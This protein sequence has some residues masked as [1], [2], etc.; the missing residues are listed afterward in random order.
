MTKVFKPT[1]EQA[2]VIAFDGS[3]FITACPGAGKTRVLIERA[4]HLL[5]GTDWK[6][7]I[8]FLSF[9]EVAVSELDARLRREGL[10]PSPAMPH[11]IGTFDSFLWRVLVAPFG[12]SGS[13]VR[14]RLIPDLELREVVPFPKARAIPLKCF[15]RVTGLGIPKALAELNIDAASQAHMT[16]ATKMRARFKARGELDYEDARLL[17]LERLNLLKKDS[18][19]TKALVARFGEIIVDEAQD[20]NP[21]D[22]RIIQWFRDAGIPVKVICDPHQSIYGF[23]GGVSTELVAFAETFEKGHRLSLTGNFRSSRNIVSAISRLKRP[24]VGHPYDE[25]LGDHRT[26]PS[27]VYLLAYKGTSVPSNIGDYF[28]KLVTELQVAEQDCPVVASTRLSA[29][30]ALGLPIDSGSG[31][32]VCRLAAAVGDLHSSFEL[33]GRKDALDELHRVVLIIEGKLTQKTYRQYMDAYGDKHQTWRPEMLRLAKQLRYA[34]EKHKDMDGWLEQA[35]DVLKAKLPAGGD[36][37]IKQVLKR[38]DLLAEALLATPAHRHPARTIHSVKG[39]EFPAVCVVLSTNK[40]KGTIEY[41][42]TGTNS[43][44]AEELRKFYVGASRAQRLLVIATPHTQ[45]KKLAILL[46]APANED[47]LKVVYL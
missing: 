7:G 47:G 2:K 37:S 3:A 6:R 45:I 20:C 40:A 28:K 14:P 11:F 39:A 16:A 4:R 43:A 17:A 33:G 34:P 26:E 35:R 9:T 42:D 21:D 44:M 8:A 25:A 46:T 15:D 24:E 29:L 13:R 41:L 18:P 1:E 27:P 22:L 36:K 32:L 5:A 31:H 12:I 10:M 19:L 30:R 23:R 38:N